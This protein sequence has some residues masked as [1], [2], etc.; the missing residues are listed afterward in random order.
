MSKNIEAQMS[1][2]AE[3][4]AAKARGPSPGWV[5]AEVIAK[6]IRAILDAPKLVGCS[7]GILCG[8]VT[9]ECKGNGY[10]EQPAPAAD[11]L[12]DKRTRFEAWVLQV[13][14]KP[15]GWLDRHWLARSDDGEGYANEYVHG[16]WIGVNAAFVMHQDLPATV[17]RS[18]E[19]SSGT[20]HISE[21]G[22]DADCALCYDTG[23]IVI[24][25][26]GPEY[27]MAP[28]PECKPADTRPTFVDLIEDAEEEIKRIAAERG[29]EI[30]KVYPTNLTLRNAS[31][32]IRALMHAANIRRAGDQFGLTDVTA[33]IIRDICEHEPQ[34]DKDSV[35]IG[36]SA[37]E[38]ILLQ[39]LENFQPQAPADDKPQLV[40]HWTDYSMVSLRIDGKVRTFTEVGAPHHSAQQNPN[41]TALR[42]ALRYL[43]SIDN[44][45]N[46]VKTLRR[47][48]ETA[49][50]QGRSVVVH[51]C[52]YAPGMNMVEF[53]LP[54]A[55]P[56]P[57]WLEMGARIALV[58]DLPVT[59]VVNEQ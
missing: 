19:D 27:V 39:R 54:N 36:V 48:V 23:S 59:E 49:K 58:E 18:V 51:V 21:L 24:D 4:Y 30:E 17:V 46:E 53:R 32:T 43:N 15:L 9:C 37:L 10:I 22:S 33:Q 38:L 56:I 11:G 29:V 26:T 12:E 50:H 55:A 20:M 16:C 5:G 40:A 8:D 2:L 52:G 41:A 28:C 34:E 14:H 35:H 3:T 25:D 31:A 47:L 13:E 45:C 42:R 7:K 6:E 44:G 1:R 57:S